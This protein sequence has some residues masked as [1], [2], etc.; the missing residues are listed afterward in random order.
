M[1]KVRYKRRR[2]EK[3]LLPRDYAAQAFDT[4]LG[5][6]VPI[7]V[8]AARVLDESLDL[9]RVAGFLRLDVLNVSEAANANLSCPGRPVCGEVSDGRPVMVILR[10]DDCGLLEAKRKK[11]LRARGGIRSVLWSK[12]ELLC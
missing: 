1:T 4:L 8:H 10:S 12:L 6:R 2:R 9:E 7:L 3:T 11:E 5:D